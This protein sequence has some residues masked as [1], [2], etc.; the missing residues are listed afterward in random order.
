M[1]HL[2]NKG[3]HSEEL[4]NNIVAR[5]KKKPFPKIKFDTTK[6]FHQ[7]DMLL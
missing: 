4:F 7:L 3:S 2:K 5:K 6:V 1:V